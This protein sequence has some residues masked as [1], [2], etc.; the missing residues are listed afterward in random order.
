MQKYLSQT[1]AKVSVSEKCK[2]ICLREMQKYL[3]QRNAKVS[4]SETPRALKL[5][6]CLGRFKHIIFFFPT[7]RLFFFITANESS[8]TVPPLGQFGFVW[9]FTLRLTLAASLGVSHEVA[10]RD[11]PIRH[12]RHI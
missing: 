4:V 5:V 6:G 8:P 12:I 3:S 2:S 10:G 9:H 1:N 11:V 7:G